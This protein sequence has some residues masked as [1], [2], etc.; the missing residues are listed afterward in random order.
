MR[1]VADQGQP[2][3]PKPAMT[4]G[5]R[6]DRT[7]NRR[8]IALGDQGGELRRPTRELARDLVEN[9][10]GSPGSRSENHASGLFRAA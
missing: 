10:L 7:Q 5:K 6:M 1:G 3:R 9:T 4:D 8:C 2:W